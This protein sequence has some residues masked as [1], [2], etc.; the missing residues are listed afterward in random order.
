MG[1]HRRAVSGNCF[2]IPRRAGTGRAKLA[3]MTL[4]GQPEVALDSA[5]LSDGWR[6]LRRLIRQ[7]GSAY[8]AT[9]ASISTPAPRGRIA[10]DEW[11]ISKS[12]STRSLVAMSE[13]ALIAAGGG[14]AAWYSPQLDRADACSASGTGTASR[15][16]SDQS[17]HAC[18]DCGNSNRRGFFRLQC[19]SCPG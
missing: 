15:A 6:R 11:M 19:V 8:I 14:L 16:C 12:F 10:T 2:S 7:E 9:R 13:P 5:A 3:E 4:D 17:G 18:E 1:I